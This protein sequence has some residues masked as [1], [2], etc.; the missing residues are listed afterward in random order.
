MQAAIGRAGGGQLA[1]VGLATS[2]MNIT[3]SA[4]VIG[5]AGAIDTLASQAFGAGR[6]EETGRVLQAR[7]YMWMLKLK[8]GRGGGC[9]L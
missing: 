5:L 1:A 4:V 8:I 2:L 7:I 3:G 9:I 6:P